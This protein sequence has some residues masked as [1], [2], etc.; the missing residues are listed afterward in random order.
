MKEGVGWDPLVR[1]TYPGIRISTKMSRI[2]N[3]G[4]QKLENKTYFIV[5]MVD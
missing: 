1:G 5:K 3:P 2:P 4:E